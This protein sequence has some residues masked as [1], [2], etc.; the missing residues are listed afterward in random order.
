MFRTY[1]PSTGRYLEPDP[2]GLV[3]G[4]NLYGYVSN[5][6]TQRSDPLG[7]AASIVCY[8][9]KDDP[10]GPL[11]CFAIDDFGNSVSFTA[12]TGGP[13][14]NYTKFDPHSTEA[15]ASDLY[16]KNG[17]LPP[18]TPL[19]VA[20]RGPAPGA[21]YPAGTPSV[22][23]PGRPPGSLKTPAG[24]TRTEVFFHGP[25]RTDG[26]FACDDGGERF[27]R[28]MMDR[29]ISTGGTSLSIE[30]IDCS[31]SCDPRIPRR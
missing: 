4:F 8:R 27:V 9:C 15:Q 12:N 28:D 29:N 2:L 11:R 14:K 19:K 3:G 24:T 31:N 23:G 10:L 30:E 25:G 17:P 1:D 5:R 16:G 13:L 18:N 22:T 21:R 20:P 7:I 26:C 6:P